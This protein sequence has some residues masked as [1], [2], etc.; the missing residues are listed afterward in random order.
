M[1]FH[2]QGISAI[3]GVLLIVL[4]GFCWKLS[5]SYGIV[6]TALPHN[7]SAIKSTDLPSIRWDNYHEFVRDIDF[8]NSTAIFNSIRAALRQ[9]P[10]DIHPVG[11]SYFPAVIPKG[12]LMYHAG[13]KVPT[14]F[15]WLAMDHEFS[16]S[17][18]LR[19]PS[20][21][22][23]SLER[24]HGRFGNGTNGDHP[25]GPPPPPPPPDEKGRGSQKMLTYRAAR[26]LNK[27]LYLDGASAAKT[28]SGEMDTQLMLSNVIKEKL[29]LTDDGENERMAERLYAARICKWGKPFGLDGIIRVEVGFEVVLCDF[30]ADNVELVSMLE[31][32]QPNQYL[33]LPAPTVI[34]KEEGWPLDENG[35]LVEDQLTDDQKAILEREDGWEKAFSNFN[36]VKSFNQ[37]RA[38][39]AHDNG[40]HRIHIDYR[41]LVS[42]INRTYIAPDPNNRRLLD[43]GMTWE[44]QLDMVDDLEKALEVGFDATQSM[45]WQL[46]FDELVLKFAPLLK[47]VSNILNSDGDINESIAINATALTLNFYFLI[48]SSAVSVVGEIVDVIYKVND[49]LIPEVYSFMTDNTTSSDLIKNVETARST[50]DGLIESLGWIELN[51][52]CERQ[53]NWD[54]VC[55]TPSWGPS[56]MGM[57]EPGSHNEGFGTHF[58][59]SRQ[60]LVINSKLQ[61]INI[62]DLMVNRNH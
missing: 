40:E 54:E 18:G 1:R 44:K 20:Y 24:R 17:F 52:R 47:S 11:V 26:D 60:R 3:I 51:Y 56:P 29:N 57:T 61:C 22:R 55:Y 59:E 6:S 7:Q 41:Y 21:G 46:A 62:N 34:S 13:S 32:V 37:L 49:L 28:D 42:G 8:D 10:S 31:M 53:C 2:R 38:G 14:T 16:Y 58:D 19:S 12:T 15:E 5:G 30:S 27:F 4:L 39:A 25:K 9:S 35:S 33:G 50:I 48:W 45:D 43:E 36:A 23:K